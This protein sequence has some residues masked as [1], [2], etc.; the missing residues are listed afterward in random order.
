MRPTVAVL[1]AVSLSCACRGSEIDLPPPKTPVN[2]RVTC[3]P[4]H[5]V[6]HVP[7]P[8]MPPPGYT[9]GLPQLECAEIRPFVVRVDMSGRPIEAFVPGRRSPA[10]D[11]CLLAE[12]QRW[13]VAFEPAR[14]CNGEPLAG[15]FR[16]D[17]EITC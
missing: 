10:L 2:V 1:F 5:P 11:A 3:E 9:C 16:T 17:W 14:E 8:A 4:P 7:L 13:P 12:V 15:E 6:G